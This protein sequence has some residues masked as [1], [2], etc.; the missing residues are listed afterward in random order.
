MSRF[1]QYLI[2]RGLLSSEQVEEALQHQAVYG[3]R[4]GTNLVE[5]GLLD[6]ERLAECLSEFHRVPL[7]P[8]PWLE[9]P[10]RAALK[11]VTRPLVERIRFIPLRLDNNLLHAAV[12]DPNDP[13]VL[14]DLRFATG[15]RI[16]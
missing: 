11:R 16:Q 1:A 5:L 7:P 6:M 14:D 13:G 12:M 3:A 10:R 4:L 15:C 2:K 8:R 9:R